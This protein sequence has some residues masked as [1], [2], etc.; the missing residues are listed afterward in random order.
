MLML[1][2]TVLGQTGFMMELLVSNSFLIPASFKNF[3]PNE[4]RQLMIINYPDFM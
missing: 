3:D 2:L 1:F 4:K